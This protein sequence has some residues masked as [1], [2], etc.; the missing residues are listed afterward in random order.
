MITATPHRNR[1]KL[2][3]QKAKNAPEPAQRLMRQRA[4]LHL[5]LAMVLASAARPGRSMRRPQY[6]TALCAAIIDNGK[7]DSTKAG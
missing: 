2:L 4:A 7:H 5:T 1:A 6:A 3:L